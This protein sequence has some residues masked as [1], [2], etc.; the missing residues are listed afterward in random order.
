MKF[1]TKNPNIEKQF[2]FFFWGGGVRVCRDSA[3][4]GTGWG[5]EGSR[6]MDRQTG[7]YQV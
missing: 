1:F 7:P 4:D 3:G 6:W 5:G 2:F